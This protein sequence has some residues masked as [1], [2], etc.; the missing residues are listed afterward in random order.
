MAED[1]YA[2][3]A[4]KFKPNKV[5][6]VLLAE[7]P[8]KIADEAKISQ[9]K[10]FYNIDYVDNQKDILLRETAKVIL[11]NNDLSVRT[12]EEKIAILN[13]LKDAGVYL[14]DVVKYAINKTDKKVRKQAIMDSMPA[15]LD[16]LKELNPERI[17]VVMKSIYDMVGQDLRE[18]GLP[19]IDVPVYSPFSPTQ[20]G[21]DY[22]TTLKQALAFCN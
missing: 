11:N 12:K 2:S 10:Y 16:E 4:T 1:I 22:K 20:K 13:G 9:L 17:I 14:V 5:K 21:L 19:I 8:P 15:L 18:A 6:I 3:M 7:S